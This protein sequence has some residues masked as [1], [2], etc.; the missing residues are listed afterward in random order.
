[1][2]DPAELARMSSPEFSQNSRNSAGGVSA[3]SVRH[4]AG[5]QNAPSCTE[6]PFWLV[7]ISGPPRAGKSRAGTCLS[8]KLDADH[9]ALSNLLKQMT[10]DH[11]DLGK[12]CLPLAFESCKDKPL[13]EFGGLT[14]RDAYIMYS[15]TILKPRHGSGCL[16]QE[17]K[18]RV[19]S[20]LSRGR[21][22]VVS[23]VGFIDEVRPL[24]NAVGGEYALHIR[25]TGQRAMH[26]EDS[27]EYL[28]L[29][30]FGLTEVE[31]ENRSCRQFLESLRQLLPCFRI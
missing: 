4:P 21:I 18:K 6:F 19:K 20:N 28:D 13:P 25:I 2:R 17:G 31:T 10:H 27:R 16:G 1:M 11:F 12:D 8:D 14:P 3:D 30:A 24:I 7:L 5:K 26:L 9:F 22:S 23:G 15:E 29:A